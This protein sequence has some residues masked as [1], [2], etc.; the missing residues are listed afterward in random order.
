MNSSSLTFLV[1]AVLMSLAGMIWHPVASASPRSV[2]L[3]YGARPP[4]AEL[5]AFDWVV[6]DPDHDFRPIDIVLPPAI[7]LAYVAIGEACP[8]RPWFGN[9]DAAWVIGENRTWDS[10][11]MDMANPSWRNFLLEQVIIPLWQK[12]YRG[13]F[14]DALDSY[15]LIEG[16]DA[17]AQQYGLVELIRELKR[18][19]PG[20]RV[21]LNRGFEILPLVSALVDMVAAESLFQSWDVRQQNYRAVSEEDRH[22]LLDRFAEVRQLGLS[23]LAIDYAPPQDRAAARAIAKEIK[24]SGCL[25]YVTDAN[26]ET[27][28]VGAVEVVPRRILV[29]YDGKS[30]PELRYSKAARY[31]QMP[32]EHL[33]YVVNY[34]DIQKPLPEDIYPDRYVGIVSWLTDSISTEVAVRLSSWWTAKID[35]GIP[36]AI[37]GKLPAHLSGDILE[38]LGIAEVEAVGQLQATTT[39]PMLGLEIQAP[40][41]AVEEV[42]LPTP[43]SEVLQGYRDECGQALA[44]A[45]ITARGGIVLDPF[46]VQV[47]PGIEQSRWVVDPIAFIQRALRLAPIQVPDISTGCQCLRDSRFLSTRAGRDSYRSLNVQER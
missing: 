37:L 7:P 17:K 1:W 38:R 44:A 21:I 4:K 26:L 24:E 43:G 18:R 15:R 30:E 19:L 25:P 14:F 31:L 47:L 16:S 3:F 13:F 29:L 6:L 39:A 40:T 9:I 36:Y 8:S 10:K 46:V 28:G 42:F 22:W 35:E 34:T 11:V 20:S 5:R 23:C 12:G 2:A 27:I 45:A 33:G 41:Q 32:I